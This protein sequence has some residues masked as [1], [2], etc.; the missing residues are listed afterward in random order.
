M[1]HRGPYASAVPPHIAGQE[2]NLSASTVLELEEAS[3]VL[4]RFDARHTG[5]VG[6]LAALLLRSESAASSQIEN[7]TSSA[8]SVAIADIGEPSGPNA[9]LIVGNARAMQ[10]AIELADRMDEA[11]IIEMHA[12]LLGESRPDAVGAWRQQAV[13]IGGSGLGP[14]RAVFVP[15]RHE[16]LPDLMADLATFMARDDLPVLAQAALAHAQFE[17]IHPFVDGNG[18]TGR[19]L[20]H[21]MLRSKGLL[22]NITIPVSAG[23]LAD[24]TRY[25]ASLGEYQQGDPEGVSSLVAEAAFRAVSEATWLLGEVGYLMEA[26]RQ[27]LGARRHALVWTVLEELPRQPVLSTR[28]VEQRFAASNTAASRAL[29]QL[30]DAGIM[31]EFTGR[32]RSRMWVADGITELLDEFG[33]RAAMRRL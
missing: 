20:L 16:L 25:F 9:R 13:W 19:A 22:Q 4:V 2:L 24:A 27:R 12:A 29:Q 8:Q 21:A 31:R 6:P 11:A 30:S 23:L 14:H 18:R 5:A 26:W 17:T 33:R 28:V 1:L 10:A 3:Q 32:Q 7:L 15:P